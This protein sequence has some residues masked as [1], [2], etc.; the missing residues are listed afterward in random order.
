MSARIYFLAEDETGKWK[1][2]FD[3]D[4][5]H[6]YVEFTQPGPAAKPRQWMSADDFLAWSPRNSLHRRALD[7]FVAFLAEAILLRA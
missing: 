6:L 5:L 3:P 4:Q 2:V 1:L 7:C